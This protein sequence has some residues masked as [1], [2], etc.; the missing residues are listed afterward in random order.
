M[1]GPITQRSEC[2]SYKAKVDGSNPSRATKVLKKLLITKNTSPEE[3]SGYIKDLREQKGKEKEVIKVIDSAFKFGHDFVVNLFWEEALT[4]QHIIMNDSSNRE[5]LLEMQEA[6][7]KAK[8]YITKYKL[9]HWNSRL[10]RYLGRL[11]DYKKEYKKA[12]EFYKKA[13]KFYKTDPEVKLDYPRNLE[14]EAFL[15]FSLIMSGS[16]NEGYKLAKTTY[17]KFFNSKEGKKLK[18]KDYQTWGIW[19][20]GIAIRTINAYVD[21]KLLFNRKVFIDW[22]NEIEKYLKPKD[23]F[24]YRLSEIKDLKQKLLLN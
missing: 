21:K 3:I 20:S 9:T 24:S 14:L 8:F 11:S 15:S 2:R 4:Y 7:L 22:L 16:L 17:R 23:L 5:A 1:L 12:V 13:I 10:Y 19:M 18:S 6:I